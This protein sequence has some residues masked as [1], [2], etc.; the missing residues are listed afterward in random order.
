MSRAARLPAGDGESGAIDMEYSVGCEH[1]TSEDWYGKEWRGIVVDSNEE[2][3][4][5]L[6]SHPPL[7]LHIFH[8]LSDYLRKNVS[9]VLS[10]ASH[11]P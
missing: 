3:R 1:D 6:R 4:I 10:P 5:A 2:V 9:E 11:T 8:D 7:F